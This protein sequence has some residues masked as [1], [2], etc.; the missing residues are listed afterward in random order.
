[1]RLSGVKKLFLVLGFLGLLTTGFFAMNVVTSCPAEAQLCACDICIYPGGMTAPLSLI[2]STVVFPGITYITTTLAAYYTLVSVA[3]TLHVT[4]KITDVT[5]DWIAWWD[6]FWYYNFKPAL[7]DMTDQLNTM[8]ATQGRED[9][10]YKDASDLNR[11]K[12]LLD[13]AEIDA[14]RAT[15]PGDN[16][17]VAGTVT[18]GMA[19]VAAFQRAYNA[20]APAER[21]PRSANAT[22]TKA[23]EGALADMQERW[24]IYTERY[25]DS[26][27]NAG[28]SGCTSDQAYVNQ[29]LD[30][31]GQIFKKDTI[32]LRDAEVKRTVDDLLIN[33]AEPRVAN[34]ISAGAVKGAQGREVAL[35]M[36]AYRARRQTIY[37]VLYQAV[38]YRAP[39]S[40][41]GAFVRAIRTEAGLSPSYFSENPSRNEIM[42]TM[43]RERFASGE[44]SVDQVDEPENNQRELVIG[45]AF[46]VMQLSD[47][48]DLLDR[49]SLML[50]AQTGLDVKKNK[51]LDNAFRS[52]PLK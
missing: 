51:P 2:F 18:G 30:V 19:R 42:E 24:Q 21:L 16:G 34:L 25:C 5:R 29:D 47:Q 45:Q 37:D 39:G 3:Y 15:R 28:N 46:K 50:A 10:G 4:D 17:C 20:A 32:D 11:T 35:E 26:E 27:Y 33:I 13:E 38:A 9:G 52:E 44:Y 8:D 36:E 43:M 6:T 1:M 40:N 14:H 31:T 48:L 41:T 22:G 23:A 49:Y 12:L 7:Q